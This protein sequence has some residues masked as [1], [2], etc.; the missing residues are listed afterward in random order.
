MALAAKG[1]DPDLP[2][3]EEAMSGPEAEGYWEACIT[4]IRTLE[5]MNVWEIVQRESWMNIIPGV[6]ALRKKRYPD[7]LVKKL[8]ARYC[9]RGDKQIHGVDYFETYS[10][11]VKWTTVRMML[12]LTAQLGL[13]TKQV[14]YTAAFVHAPI[15][16]PPNYSRMSAEEKARQ[17]VFVEMPRGFRQD[18]K[19]LKLKKNLYGLKSAPRQWTNMAKASM[20]KLGFTSVTEV[21]PC[22]F[23][24]DK[25]ICLNYVDDC[26]MFA[27]DVKDIDAVIKGLREQNFILEEEE[28]VAGFLGVHIERSSTKVRL[29]QV[30]LAQRIVE[31][32]GAQDLPPV[33]TPAVGLLGKDPDGDPPNGTFNYA[34]VIGM[35]WHLY[36]HS[37]PDLGF[38]VSQAARFSFAP[39][40]SHEKALIRIGQYLKGTLTQGL[41][42]KPMEP[43]QFKMDVYVDSDF[44]GLYGNE[45]RSD[46][47]NVKSRAGY[48]VLL[49]DCPII[50]SS[51]LMDSICLSTMMAEYYALSMAMREVLPLR[52][53]VK[54]LATGC[55]LVPRCLTTFR[56]TVW[57]DNMGALTLANLDPGQNTTRSRH[58]DSKVHWFRSKLSK[59]LESTPE[60]HL[61]PDGIYVKKVDSKFQLA[62][63]FTKPLVKETFEFLRNLLMGW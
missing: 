53:L 49:N 34:S 47:D 15:E 43:G 54:T 39:K 9:V 12:I 48:V 30:G 44:L 27:K 41:E 18:G 38:A 17:G 45:E 59:A 63:I 8:K 29:T 42:M 6:W 46:P 20:E 1:N 60:A 24:S 7:G 5:K 13:K 21:D 4:E 56:T 3:W 23:I 61:D 62:D 16:L 55:D 35:L 52:D 58:F 26:L 10:P 19:V 22:L 32:L 28:D 31:A 11:V 51:R 40:R 36:G 57:E 14:D 50:W 2:S 33:S 37:R 25:V